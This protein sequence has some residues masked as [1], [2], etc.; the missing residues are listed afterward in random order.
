MCQERVPKRTQQQTYKVGHVE[1]IAQTLLEGAVDLIGTKRRGNQGVVGR[2][3]VRCQLAL[4]LVDEG[5]LGN[6][7]FEGLLDG[8]QRGG[9]IG[10]GGTS[11]V[12][13]EGRGSGGEEASPRGTGEGGGGSEAHDGAVLMSSS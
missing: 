8:G 12:G 10:G 3:A 2:I 1:R 13:S 5:R 7:T 4:D 11:R 9:W 6:G